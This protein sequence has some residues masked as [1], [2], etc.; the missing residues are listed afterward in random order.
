M[1]IRIKIKVINEGKF[2]H[3][4]N[5]TLKTKCSKKLI[6][7]L[8][9]FLNE[10]IEEHLRDK[11]EGKEIPLE[12][13]LNSKVGGDFFDSKGNDISKEEYFKN[14]MNFEVNGI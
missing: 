8:R 10:E 3:I 4:G 11:Y 5:I 2:K 6:M 7:R 13:S 1:V 12:L 14:E 9:K